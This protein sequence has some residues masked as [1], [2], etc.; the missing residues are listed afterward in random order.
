MLA[1]LAFGFAE[2]Q[3]AA[4]GPVIG[5]RLTYTI[6]FDKFDNVAYAE[7]FTASRGKLAGRD[8]I[9]IRSKLKTYDFLGAAFYPINEVRKTF[10]SKP[11]IRCMFP[12]R[13]TILSNPKKL[14]RVIFQ[15]R[16]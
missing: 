16:L 4:E 3:T 11:D 15:R 12:G 2:N 8:A 7:I 9:E 5:E 6:S 10:A 1:F 13:K 14:H